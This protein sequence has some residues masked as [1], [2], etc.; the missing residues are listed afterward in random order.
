[1]L[2]PGADL[3][4]VMVH[5]EGARDISVATDGTLIIDTELGPVIQS[6]P[7]TWQVGRDGRKCEVA[8]K[9]ALLGGDRFGFVAPG[10]DRATSLTIDPG[11]IWSTFLGGNGWEQCRA[12]AVDANGVLMVAGSTLSTN[13]SNTPASSKTVSRRRS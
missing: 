11:L 3:S 9:F 6:V 5:V 4:L 8:C 10:W 13:F 2:E 12:L 7:K 1:M